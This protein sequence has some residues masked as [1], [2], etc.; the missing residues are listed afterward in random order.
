V[1]KVT[2]FFKETVNFQQHIP[3]KLKWLAT[4]IYKLYD[5][6]RYTYDMHMY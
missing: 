2:S 3:K 4:E 5:I 6:W 1:V